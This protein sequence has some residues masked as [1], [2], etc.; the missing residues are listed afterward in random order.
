MFITDAAYARIFSAA[1]GR[2]SNV[3]EMNCM[4]GLDLGESLSAYLL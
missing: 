1:I 3:A 2:F 4:F